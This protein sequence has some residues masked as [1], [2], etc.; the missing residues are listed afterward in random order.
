MNEGA[1]QGP[2]EY[3]D[4]RGPVESSFQE[5]SDA[6]ESASINEAGEQS[7][8]GSPQG[9]F[10]G[11]Q[12]PRR[13]RRRGGRRHRRRKAEGTQISPAADATKRAE[14]QGDE[15]EE[16]FSESLEEVTGE[17]EPIDAAKGEPETGETE[18]VDTVPAE[19]EAVIEEERERAIEPTAEAP[20]V[21]GETVE[22]PEAKPKRKRA[23]RAKSATAK[24]AARPKR[25][26][27]RKA[28]KGGS[29]PTPQVPQ[30]SDVV[31]TGSTDKHL[32]SDEPVLPPSL[33]RPRSYSDLDAIPDD[34]D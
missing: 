28:E 24:P 17:A 11:E 23:S 13:R 3:S 33:S 20:D 18:A 31:R 4:D 15:F 34:Y 22:E 27:P 1:G 9:E 29:V 10:G 5:A 6:D 30:P 26:P 21:E 7:P 12:R 2:D 8:A 32:A 19:M 25:T 16:G 14:P